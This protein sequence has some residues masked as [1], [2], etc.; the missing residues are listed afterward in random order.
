MAGMV[1]LG[2]RP[3]LASGVTYK[4]DALGRVISVTYPNNST[5][6]YTYDAAGN[7]KT[8]SFNGTKGGTFAPQA[9]IVL[10]L[11]GGFVLPV[12]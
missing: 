12:P 5:I 6:S 8:V 7:R 10:P 1:G 4:Y 9:V 2:A 11:L 3:V